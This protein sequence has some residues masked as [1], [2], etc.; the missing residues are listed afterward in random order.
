MYQ[1]SIWIGGK[2]HVLGRFD[3][4]KQAGMIYDRFVVDKSTEAVSYNLNYPNMSDQEREEALDVEAP[5]KK[6]RK[7]GTPKQTTG[8]GG[9]GG[10][11]DD[12]SDEE[13]AG[14]PTPSFQA[15]P[16]FERDPMLDQLYADAQH[17]Q[18]QQQQQDFLLSTLTNERQSV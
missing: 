11:G 10:G 9:G 2:Q 14:E 16:I 7:R 17:E 18:Q 1:A 5:P 3:N 15:P 13:E 6:K 8:G 12:E 4:K